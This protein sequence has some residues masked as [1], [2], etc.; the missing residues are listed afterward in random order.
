MKVN[1]VAGLVELLKNHGIIVSPVVIYAILAILFFVVLLL[2][3]LGVL[4]A[5]F[6]DILANWLSQFTPMDFS[7]FAAET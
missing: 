5:D 4:P 7:G 3:A 1:I 6:D 2:C